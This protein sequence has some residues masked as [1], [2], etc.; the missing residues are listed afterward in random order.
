MCDVCAWLEGR[1]QEWAVDEGE[2]EASRAAA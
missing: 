2:G 1:G